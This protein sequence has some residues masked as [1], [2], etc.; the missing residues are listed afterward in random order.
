MLHKFK[1][2]QNTSIDAV[3]DIYHVRFNI[4]LLAP[5]QL[6]DD[7]SIIASQLSTDLALPISKQSELEKNYKLLTVKS[8][9]TKEYCIFEIKLPLISRDVY[10][11]S[12][13]MTIPKQLGENM[14]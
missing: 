5:E 3:T 14:V 8:R 4:L 7:L 9:I 6:R 11:I 1:D 2:I 12:K 10:K 13:L